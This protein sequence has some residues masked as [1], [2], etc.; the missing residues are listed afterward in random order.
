M[1]LS[2]ATCA[3]C[4]VK[5]GI[6]RDRL[7]ELR[8]TGARFY[9]PNGHRLGFGPSRDQERI[10][11]LERAVAQA[12]RLRDMQQDEWRQT[13]ASRELLLLAL[14]SCPVR[15]GWRS[16]KVF[17]RFAE[18]DAQER[19]ILRITADVANHLALEHGLELGDEVRGWLAEVAR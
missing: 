10:A 8:K 6:E 1:Y 17:P 12:R 19:G 13:Y 15:C 3:A 7:E 5:F 14:R 16:R 9:C 2:E 18:P 4:G 11:E